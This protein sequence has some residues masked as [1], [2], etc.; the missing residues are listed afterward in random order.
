MVSKARRI[1]LRLIAVE[2][3]TKRIFARSAPPRRGRILLKCT[4]RFR[5]AEQSRMHACMHA[6]MHVC[7]AHTACVIHL[8]CVY[9]A[10]HIFYFYPW[11]PFSL[12]LLSFLL[13]FTSLAV[14]LLLSIVLCCSPFSLNPYSCIFNIVRPFSERSPRTFALRTFMSLLSHCYHYFWETFKSP[15]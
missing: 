8:A 15:I 5:Y 6:Y 7:R 10:C 3:A 13:A 11:L 14:I 4:N 1:S 2:I 9:L 12:F